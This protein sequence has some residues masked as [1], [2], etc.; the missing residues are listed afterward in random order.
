MIDEKT[1]NRN[2]ELPHSLNRMVEDVER[3][4]VALGMI[5]GDVHQIISDVPK[6]NPSAVVAPTATDDASL[7]YAQGSMWYDMQSS[8]VYLCLDSSVAIWRDVT[9]SLAASNP[10]LEI[11]DGGIALKEGGV[12]NN[13]IAPNAAIEQNKLNLNIGT[14][15]NDLVQLNGNGELPMVPG[16]NLIDAG[17]KVKFFGLKVNENGNL[18][19]HESDDNSTH[20]VDDY[21]DSFLADTDTSISIDSSGHLL[22]SLT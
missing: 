7:G 14:G 22:V 12:R 9:I 8:R 20:I 6:T 18:V 21:I 1:I 10:A 11:V 17:A 19:V 16:K 4:R 13:H 2:Y 3:I 15:P 5:D